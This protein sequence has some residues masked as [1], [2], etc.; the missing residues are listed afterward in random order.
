[1]TDTVDRTGAQ[2]YQTGCTGE[3]THRVQWQPKDDRWYGICEGCA[4]E[5]PI[6]RARVVEGLTPETITVHP[7]AV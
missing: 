1:M 3:P 4:D 7:R 2:C 6:H 5:I